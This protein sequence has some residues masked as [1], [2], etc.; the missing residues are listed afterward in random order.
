MN[1]IIF[2]AGASYATHGLP[3]TENVLKAWQED[4]DG[5]HAVLALALDWAVPRWRRGKLTLEDAWKRIDLAW[6]EQVFPGVTRKVNP[7]DMAHRRR[8]WELAETEQ[9]RETAEPWYYRKQVQSARQAQWSTEQFLS[10]AAG[11]EL[12]RLIQRY[13]AIPGDA[14]R[15][16]P[17]RSLLEQARPLGSVL[18]FNYD[19][20]AEQCLDAG[21]Q[22]W[23]YDIPSGVGTIGVLKPHGS[24]NCTHVR[25][26]EEDQIRH[27]VRLRLEDMG[28]QGKRF[29]QNLVVGL[30]VKTE[31]TSIEP[32]DAIRLHFQRILNASEVALREAQCVFVVGYSFPSADTTF[33][34]VVARACAS[35]AERSLSLVV[36]DTVERTRAEGQQLARLR[37]L[38]GPALAGAIAY[39]PHGFEAWGKSHDCLVTA[40]PRGRRTR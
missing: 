30:R 7:L 36:I 2:G 13:M 18:S 37:D 25:E 33:L 1:V 26:G 12:R 35:R 6:K 10:V 24:V 31:H 9:R 5:R 23:T 17:Y 22:P 16:A 32:S 21:E 15:C 39:C 28:Y 3:L 8:V 38:F 27:N 34:D 40:T 20:L 19:T 29:V 14:A 4:I 11:W